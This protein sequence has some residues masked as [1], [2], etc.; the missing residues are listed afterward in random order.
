MKIMTMTTILIEMMMTM[1]MVVSEV[2][3]LQTVDSD[4]SWSLRAEALTERE[5]ARQREMVVTMTM[6]L[7]W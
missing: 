2:V 3:P 4:P 7:R 1:M 5:R 6:R